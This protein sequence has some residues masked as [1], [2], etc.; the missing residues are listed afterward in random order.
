MIPKRIIL[1]NF[2]SFGTPPTEIVLGDDEPLW[3]LAG[4]NGVGKSAVFD[5]VTF[6]LYG[7]HR[8]GASDHASLVRHG[9][10]GF[11]VVFEFEFNGTDYRITRNR[12]RTGR[13]SQRVERRTGDRWVPIELPSASG[14][15]DPVKL[16]TERTL[17]LGCAAFTTSVLLRQGKADEIITAA[18][19]QRLAI[20]KK[21]IGAEQYESLSNRVHEA[22]RGCKDR[23]ADLCTQRDGL[24]PVT[25]AEVEQAREALNQAEIDRTKAHEQANAATERLAGARHW[26]AL[27]GEQQ[28]LTRHI[29]EANV[30]AAKAAQIQ[31][32]KARLDA[33]AA[34]VPLLSQ[35]I[36]LRNRVT[37]G[38]K[39][40]AGLRADVDR[41][42][43][44][45][46][47]EAAAAS[48]ARQKA[49]IH[50]ANAEQHTSLAR[51]LREEIERD[52]RCITAAEGVAKLRGQLAGF[53]P[54]LATRLREAQ[55]RFRLA[56]DNATRAGN[57]R[58]EAGG[59]LK[60]CRQQEQGFAAV[61]VGVPC[62]RCGQVVTAEHAASERARLAGEMRTL[63]GRVQ[64]ANN[65]E[66]AATALAK[67]ADAEQK[68]LDEQVQ[69][70]TNLAARLN[71]QERILAELGM[72]ADVDNLRRQVEAKT[73]AATDHENQAAG[74][75]RSRDASL[76]EATAYDNQRQKRES[77]VAQLEQEVRTLE[78]HLAKSQGQCSTLQGRLAP[79]WQAQLGTC[80]AAV[81]D[82]LEV[83]RDQLTRSGVTDLWQQ[84]VQDATL[85]DEWARRL[86]AVNQQMDDI[87]PAWRVPVTEAERDLQTARRAVAD[88]GAARDAAKERADDLSRRAADCDRLA[89]E[90]AVAERKAD[91]HRKLDELLGKAG[92]Q[93]ELVRS[94]ERE[95]VRLANNTLHNLSDGELSVELADGE[96]GDNEAF[97]LRVRRAD[98]PI[99]IGVHFL[100][101][102]QKFRVAISVA[103]AVGRFAAGQARLLESVIIDEG[104][105]SLDRDGLRAAADELN[106]LRQH[107][108]R[109]VVV[110]H[111]EEFAE[112]FPVVIRLTPGDNGTA[113][114]AF[115]R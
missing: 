52:S 100:S 114:E 70:R 79:D 10:N 94:A 19:T 115:R 8:G 7:E 16:W 98:D 49:Q 92:L 17:G 34:T 25:A 83:E 106:R 24:T 68:R 6:A 110:S 105:G 77:Q 43:A 20:L 48:Q 65:R 96:D 30:R 86:G 13:P 75:V 113:A 3:V 18:S 15:Q 44:E 53:P 60:R 103:L 39:K 59:L 99:P 54:D 62:S 71:E 87:L 5:A 73:A 74:A 23:L 12:P 11:R 61:G 41:L 50:G 4:A 88:T 57:D 27:Q 40:L 35:L 51:R 111:Q 33:L 67:T 58:A 109:I 95:I 26:A 93:R 42:N 38:E 56:T 112:R 102:S 97:S 47:V 64:E 21:I 1:E 84:L 78:Q 69:Q 32:D 14:R 55:D 72:S 9:A 36:T 104:F 89:A 22:A 82:H 66:A 28:E 29:G 81:V 2:L 37:T 63:E 76:R 108:R 101:G 80:D 46:E 45:R 85:R 90:I 107:L 91:L 31:A